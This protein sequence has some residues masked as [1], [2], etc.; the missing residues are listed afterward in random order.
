MSSA[1]ILLS[2]LKVKVTKVQLRILQMLS[3][4]HQAYLKR[5]WSL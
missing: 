2:A 1:A 5:F 3:R 4:R